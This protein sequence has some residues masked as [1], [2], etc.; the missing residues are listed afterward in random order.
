MTKIGIISTYQRILYSSAA[1]RDLYYVTVSK[2][3]SSTPSG[4]NGNSEKVT[5][6]KEDINNKN[7]VDEKSFNIKTGE[8]AV[9]N[10]DDLLKSLEEAK[11][12][13]LT[14]YENQK[15]VL[16]EKLDSVKV[17]FGGKQPRTPDEEW[18]A[19]RVRIIKLLCYLS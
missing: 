17:I 9:G 13:A 1:K 4:S 11:K 12:L 8:I 6:S 2:S 3:F 18:Y 16:E 19:K 10:K 5:S 7:D 14:Q 15:K